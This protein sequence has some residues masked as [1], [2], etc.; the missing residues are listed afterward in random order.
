[1]AGAGVHRQQEAWGRGGISLG[2]TRGGA[3]SAAPQEASRLAGNKC[4]GPACSDTVTWAV[5]V[6]FDFPSV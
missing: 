3:G 2:T 4:G 6:A 1:M 5:C